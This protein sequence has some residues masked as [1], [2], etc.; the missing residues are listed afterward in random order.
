MTDT[1]DRTDLGL[2][3]DDV[4]ERPVVTRRPLHAPPPPFQPLSS[5]VRYP[6]GPVADVED[7][8]TE[9]VAPAPRRLA[10]VLAPWARVRPWTR[11]R[12]VAGLL[13]VFLGGL[14]LH[15]LYLGYWRRGLT[16]LAVTVVG[17]F[18][19]LGIAAVVMGVWGFAEGLLVLTVR[20]GRFAHDARGRPLRG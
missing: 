17:G 11:S 5:T 20:R 7:V 19:T 2:D 9:P 18:L 6:P 8:V 14:G 12:V 1:I 10:R 13:G 15:R 4:G 3:D 16:M